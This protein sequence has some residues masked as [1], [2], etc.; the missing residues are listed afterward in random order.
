MPRVYYE[1]ENLTGGCCPSCCQARDLGG[2]D[3][4]IPCETNPCCPRAHPRDE[5][6]YDRYD[7]RNSAGSRGDDSRDFG[8]TVSDNKSSS[9][10]AMTG[11]SKV[12]GASK[13]QDA[14]G[15]KN[16]DKTGKADKQAAKADGS[17]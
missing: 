15:D 8:K 11:S 14:K 10:T 1:D 2:H 17:K 16:K 3:F 7:N 6:A 9:V 13:N 12:G 5:S 4:C